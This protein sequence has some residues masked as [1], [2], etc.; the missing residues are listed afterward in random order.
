ARLQHDERLHDRA[1]RLVGLADHRGVR[2][3][4]VLHEAALDLGWP[5]AVAR[6]LDDVVRA[7]LVPELA[8]RIGL[9][10]VARAAPLA[11]ELVL[12]RLR[13]LPVLEEEHGIIG[14]MH[15][16]LAQLAGREF[17]ALIIDH[18]YTMAGIGA[19]NGAR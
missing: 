13:I 9:A 10:L 18:R 6:A 17:A 1:A 4:A 15:R 5:D 19:S 12:R 14:A 11:D 3:R 16:N 8:V 2:D 7:A